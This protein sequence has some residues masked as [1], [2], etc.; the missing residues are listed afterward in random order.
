MKAKILL[1]KDCLS[2]AELEERVGK[3]YNAQLFAR[4][5]GADITAK[6]LDKEIIIVE[7]ALASL[8][9]L[10]GQGEL[11]RGFK[12]VSKPAL[13]LIDDKENN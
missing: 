5:V 6:Q 1:T 12:L 3:L 10:H 11:A 7:L 4:S 9:A 8:Q 2:I 13:K